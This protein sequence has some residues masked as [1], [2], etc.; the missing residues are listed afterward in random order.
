MANSTYLQLCNMIL[1]QFNEVA[2][3]SDTFDTARGL[4]ASVKDAVNFII[5]DINGKYY[6][7]NFNLVIG[8]EKTLT[9]GEEIYTFEGDFKVPDWNSFYIKNDG[10]LSTSTQTLRFINKEEYFRYR[11]DNDVDSST[12]GLGVPRFVFPYY[13]NRFGVSPSPDKAYTVVYNYW[14]VPTL[15]SASTDATVIPAEWNHVIILGALWYL[16]LFKE[17]NN[18][19]GMLERRYMEALGNMRS[20]LINVDR[21]AVDTR[22]NFGQRYTSNYLVDGDN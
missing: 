22:V 11:R 2:F 10:T 16:A 5:S 21:S 3:T 8:Q 4:H 9:A 13:N 12:S 18:K 20:S 15:L 17:D 1:R 19:A 7:W 6:K 14:N